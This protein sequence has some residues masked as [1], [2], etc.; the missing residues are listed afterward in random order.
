MSGCDNTV[1]LSIKLN[2]KK[3]TRCAFT[4]SYDEN[5]YIKYTLNYLYAE[6]KLIPAIALLLVMLALE[7][8]VQNVFW[9]EQNE[10]N[11]FAKPKEKPTEC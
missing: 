5:K 11:L 7:S 10:C 6:I 8:R 4:H 9:C 1:L 2:M 3:N